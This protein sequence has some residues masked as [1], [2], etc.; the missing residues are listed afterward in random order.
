MM[1]NH[2]CLKVAVIHNIARARKVNITG[3]EYVTKASGDESETEKEK[4]CRTKY[5]N[6]S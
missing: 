3:I 1:H 5:R 4:Y 2:K 6:R